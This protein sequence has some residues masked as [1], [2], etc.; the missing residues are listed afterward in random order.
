MSV[1]TAGSPMVET[2]INF[3]PRTNLDLIKDLNLPITVCR[4]LKW[5]VTGLNEKWS[6]RESNPGPLAYCASA[7]PLSYNSHKQPPLFL[8]L[9]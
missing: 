1:I 3:S 5:L 6:C 9:T 4:P 8:A 7:L 2:L